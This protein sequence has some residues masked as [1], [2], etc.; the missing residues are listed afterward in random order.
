MDR[1]N[2]TIAARA[3]A[4]ALLRRVAA[5]LPEVLGAAVLLLAGWRWSWPESPG[6]RSRRR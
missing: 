4:S 1:S 5:R 3:A 6:P 2:W